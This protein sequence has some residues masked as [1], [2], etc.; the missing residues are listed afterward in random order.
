MEG[1]VRRIVD[2]AVLALKNLD[3]K[4]FVYDFAGLFPCDFH[5]IAIARPPANLIYSLVDSYE[6]KP[7]DRDAEHSVLILPSHQNGRS[8]SLD[9][10]GCW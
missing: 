5:A 1:H 7:A 9:G 8:G 10:V 6:A 2:A 4:V 3:K